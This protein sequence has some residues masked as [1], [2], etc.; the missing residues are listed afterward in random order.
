MDIKLGQSPP[1]IDIEIR[2]K[3]F[4]LNVREPVQ[5]VSPLNN[6]FSGGKRSRREILSSKIIQ[7]NFQDKGHKFLV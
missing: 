6:G 1:K 7:E 5:E 3:K 2:Q 4:F